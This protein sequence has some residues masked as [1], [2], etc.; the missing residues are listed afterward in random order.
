LGLQKHETEVFHGIFV[1]VSCRQWC[2]L[3]VHIIIIDYFS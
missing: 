1:Y 3:S 2:V